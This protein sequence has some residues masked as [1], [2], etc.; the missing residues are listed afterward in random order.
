[1]NGDYS[2]L[3]KSNSQ[4]ETLKSTNLCMNSQ[5]N[6]LINLFQCSFTYEL[7]LFMSMAGADVLIEL[8]KR[9]LNHSIP[10]PRGNDTATQI[11]LIKSQV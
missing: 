9:F 2:V 3:T 8:L 10:F 6:F 4:L 7:V 11:S 1:M 5:L